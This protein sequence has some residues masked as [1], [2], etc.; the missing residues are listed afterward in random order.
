MSP[1]LATISHGCLLPAR[2]YSAVM[3]NAAVVRRNVVYM[4]RFTPRTDA[5]DQGLTLV[6][7]FAQRERSLWDRGCIRGCLEDV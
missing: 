7:F 4:G 2:K 6:H 5:M 3:V 1:T